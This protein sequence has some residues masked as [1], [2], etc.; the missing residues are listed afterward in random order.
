MQKE[1]VAAESVMI[2]VLMSLVLWQRHRRD[3]KRWWKQWRAKPKRP[4][5]LRAREP[6]DCQACRIAAAE[7]GPE[8]SQARRPWSEV[9][10]RSGRPKVHDSSG[11]ACMNPFCPYY[12]DTDPAFHA[13]RWDG[14]RNACEATNQWE[15]GAC[16]R[17]HTA[18]L[19]TPMY[20][21]KTSS[22]QVALA[23]HLAMKGLNI[24]DIS[25]VLEHSPTTITRWLEGDG[26]HSEQLH[27]QLFKDLSI[28]HIQVDEL[29][30]RVRR[31]AKRVWV[32]TA[33]DVQSKAWL[34][35]HVGRRTQADAHR[36]VHHVK[37]VL[38]NGCVPVFTSDGLR[39]YFYALTA[40]FGQWIHQEGKRK[41]VWQALPSLLYGQ[42]RKIKAGRKLKR[43][44]TKMLCG[45]RSV[46]QTVQQSIGL[47]GQIQTVYVERL[48]L[49]IRH[50]V[51]ALRRRTWAIAHHVRTLRWR[52]ALAAAYYNFCRTH[53]SL[54]VDMGNGRY[55]GRTPAMAL[56]VTGHPWSVREFITH[57]V[58]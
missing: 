43:V 36:L 25:E 42:F 33:Q 39:Q 26:G 19:G 16:E 27:E 32:W 37:R 51:A 49:T 21:L 54:R 2:L 24:A 8:R 20:R 5:T 47:S 6:N 28:V 30:T 57:P 3:L 40:H 13:L 48:N 18:R 52:V 41:P 31:W 35:W 45:E 38:A 15:C 17:K 50:T 23:T 56:G 46:L 53:H 55:R 1:V 29:Y 12:K 10:S 58:Y 9:K 11:Q 34:A 7:V 22:E 4:W 14:Q 44:Y